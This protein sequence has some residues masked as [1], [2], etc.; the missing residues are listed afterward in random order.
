MPPSVAHPGEANLTH[1]DHPKITH[2]PDAPPGA[3]SLP[4][5]RSAQG[6]DGGDESL[7]KG[8][9][10]GKRVSPSA[11]PPIPLDQEVA[12]MAHEN[13]TNEELA[14]LIQR[15]TEAA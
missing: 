9:G 12:T 5:V 4:C 1:Y 6:A 14:A 7:S 2:P 15:T 11:K 3:P 8:S 13:V 10:M